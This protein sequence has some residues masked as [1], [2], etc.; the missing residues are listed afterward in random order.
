MTQGRAAGSW[1]IPIM[2]AFL[3]FVAI[4]PTFA[5]IV[6][7]EVNLAQYL[8]VGDV[9]VAEETIN[10][11]R[12]IYYV[13]EGEKIFITEGGFT[14]RHPHTN[15]EFIVF[16]KDIN[17]A[18]QI[19][20]YHIPTDSTIQ[21]TNSSTNLKP[22]VSKDGKVVWERWMRDRWQIFFYDGARVRQ[23]TDGDVSVNADIERDNIVYARQDATG[24]WRSVVYSISKNESKKMATGLASKKPKLRNGRIVLAGAG[25][26][27]QLPLTEG[28]LAPFSATPTPTTTVSIPESVSF[29]EVAQ[30]LEATLSAQIEPEAS[31][32]P[33]LP[34]T[35]TPIP[36][37]TL[38]PEPSEEASPSAI[39]L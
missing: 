25:V 2:V 36:S 33:T 14:S 10:G 4:R 13:F 7:R 30:E 20:L 9:E 3:I 35:P 31:P 39:S 18:G 1:L 32:S 29:E 17:G 8:T 26:E 28:L 16:V 11:S 19:F 37:P 38:T 22:K 5:Q 12:Q 24:G 34:L 6:E 15:G 23:L 21:V 27:K